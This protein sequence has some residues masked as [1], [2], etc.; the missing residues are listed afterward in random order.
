MHIDYS[1]GEIGQWYCLVWAFHIHNH[2]KFTSRY[3]FAIVSTVTFPYILLTLASPRQHT[4]RSIFWVCGRLLL[5]KGGQLRSQTCH[6][7]WDKY[8]L[9]FH[10]MIMYTSL[11]CVVS[12][13]LS[14]NYQPIRMSQKLACIFKKEKKIGS[15][16]SCTRLKTWLLKISFMKSDKNIVM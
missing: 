4:R 14:G 13:N 2:G 7:C 1:L 6:Q 5:V 8:K 16:F 3:S 11:H 15:K 10:L 9:C 12:W